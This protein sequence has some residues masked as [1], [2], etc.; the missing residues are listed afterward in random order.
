MSSSTSILSLRAGKS[1]TYTK[2]NKSYNSA[3]VKSSVTDVVYVTQL[4][5]RN[6]TQGDKMLHGGLDKALCVFTQGSYD[7]LNKEHQLELDSG[8]F[9]E[10]IVLNTH[11]N[12]VCLGDVYSCGEAV[13]EV[14]QPRQ[15]CW[16]I[17]DIMGIKNLTSLLVKTH[18]TGFYLRV[19]K[20]G[21]IFKEDVFILQTRTHDKMSIEFINSCYYDAKNNQENIKDILENKALANAYKLAL[22]K[23]FRNKS[24]G[25]EAFQ[26]DKN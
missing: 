11:D 19:L 21:N 3:Y 23:R 6:D 2:R 10:N 22:L 26:N 24:V 16:K 5:L 9:G 13:F 15:P 7:F 25:I 14:C 4:G 18:K 1:H 20:E 17:S 12:E 8:S